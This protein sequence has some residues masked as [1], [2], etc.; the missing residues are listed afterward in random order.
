MFKVL[1]SLQA[2]RKKLTFLDRRTKSNPKTCYNIIRS[3]PIN[4][5]QMQ[6]FSPNLGVTL[7]PT[8][9]EIFNYQITQLLNGVYA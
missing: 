2:A 1:T 7:G 5:L 6:P 9:P 4:H 3:N 8:G